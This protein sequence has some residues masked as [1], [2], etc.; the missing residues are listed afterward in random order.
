ME[1]ITMQDEILEQPGSHEPTEFH[2]TPKKAA[3]AGWIGSVLEYYDFFIYGTVAALVFPTVFFPAGNPTVATVGA[4]ATFGVGYVARP[5]GAFFMGHFGDK[6]GR[7]KVLVLCLLMMGVSTFL[8][9]CLPSYGQIGIW[10]PILLVVLRLAQGFAVSGELA[11]ASSTVLEHAPFG[12]RGFFASFTLSGTQAGQIL[13]SAVFL[14]LAAFMSPEALLAWGWRIPFWGSV[15]VI[16]AGYLIRRTLDETPAFLE[17]SAHGEVP[18]APLVIAFKDHLPNMVRVF[19]MTFVNAVAITLTPFSLTYATSP[20]YGVRIS[21]TTMLWVLIVLNFV[22]LAAIPLFG[23]LSDRIRRRPVFIFG[24][25]ASAAFMWPY[26]WSISTGHVVLV[27]VFAILMSGIC[28]S[29][30][31]AVW[32]SFW[33]EQFPT[34]ARVSAMAVSTQL[35]FGLT[36]FVATIDAAVG[37]PGSNPMVPVGIIVGIGCLISAVSAVTAKETSKIH[38]NDLGLKAPQEDETSAR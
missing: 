7:K 29:A 27:F 8:V 13:A 11:G 21:A 3:L 9:G 14:P 10:A 19:F 34:K 22:A 38:L 5:I 2:K 26:L 28:Y 33:P 31:N 20:S 6:F 24:A 35:G 16:V 25:I 37:P 30:F 12:R 36:G 4:L 32:P 1:R 17:E 15:V 23:A 18:R